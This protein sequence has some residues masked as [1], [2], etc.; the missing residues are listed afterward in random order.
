MSLPENQ[1]TPLSTVLPRQHRQEHISLAYVQ[2]VAGHA[3][4]PCARPMDYGIDLEVKYVV[5]RDNNRYKQTGHTLEIQVKSTTNREIV[6][7]ELVYDLDV[8][9]YNELI[10][11][12][13][14]TPAI[15]VVFC[16][17]TL[18]DDW[19]NVT[20]NDSVFQHCGY[21]VSLR[22]MDPSPNAT[23]QRVRIPLI[24]LFDR[25]SLSALMERIRR[26]EA[27]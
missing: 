22:G 16:M 13:R 11:I 17:P 9:T 8:N 21:W 3:G 4:W 1:P 24:Q 6:G 18:E 27:I 10:R 23:T 14:G 26:G 2:A 25:V 19:F 15:L 5:A 20:G 7:D 12:D